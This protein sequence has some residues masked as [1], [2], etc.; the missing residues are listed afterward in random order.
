MYL[1]DFLYSSIFLC[2]G[3]WA[4]LV[5]RLL[6]PRLELSSLDLKYSLKTRVEG[7]FL[8]LVLLGDSGTQ[9]CSLVGGL[10][11]TKACSEKNCGG[12]SLSFLFFPRPNEGSSFAKD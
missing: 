11:V 5:E 7:L 4:L 9:R 12:S 1:L 3:S 2:S 6:L 10:K 8:S